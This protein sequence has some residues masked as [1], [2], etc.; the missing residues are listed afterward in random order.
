M[1]KAPDPHLHRPCR[2]CMP[3]LLLLL[4]AGVASEVRMVRGGV[5]G[6]V[7]VLHMDLEPL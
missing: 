1:D 6:P 7:P 5:V 4:R 3:L 2:T